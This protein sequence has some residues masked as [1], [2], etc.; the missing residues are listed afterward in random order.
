MKRKWYEFGQTLG[1]TSTQLHD[2]EHETGQ[3]PEYYFTEVLTTL[4]DEGSKVKISWGRMAD[5][6]KQLGYEELASHLAKK[7][8]ERRSGGG[9]VSPYYKYGIHVHIQQGKW[10]H[11]KQTASVKES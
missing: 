2:I 9:G 8:G 4:L 10:R 3:E 7:Y 1:L 6:V 11:L 5:A